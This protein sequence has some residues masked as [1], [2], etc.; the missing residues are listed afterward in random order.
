MGNK[1]DSV[2]AW[3]FLTV[4][5]VMILNPLSLFFIG[6]LILMFYLAVHGCA[7]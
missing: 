5:A 6:I 3:E 2:G 4:V 7:C 1:K